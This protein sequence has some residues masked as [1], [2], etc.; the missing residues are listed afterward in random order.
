MR[1]KVFVA[2]RMSAIAGQEKLSGIFRYL[3]ERHS[4]EISLVR[5][6][7]EFTPER[8]RA[9]LGERFDGFIVSIPNTE[10][11]AVCLAHSSIP[12]IVMDI[13]DPAL[14]ARRSNILF[15][16]NSAEKIGTAA[17]LE[18]LG[19]GTCRSYAF[20]HNPLVA[21]WSSQRLRAFR[22]ALRDHGF[23]C[24][25]LAS[26]NGL[27]KI[28]RPVGVL[29]ANDDC[30]FDVLEYC[31]AH[32][33]KVPRDM[34]VLG[35]NNDTLICEHCRPA[36]SSIQPDYEQ[37]GFLAAQELDR[38]M[39]AKKRS[40]PPRTV[41]VGIRQIVRRASTAPYSPSGILV[42]KAVAYIDANA[43]HDIT[44]E[45]VVHHLKCSRRLADL[46]FRQL[47]GETMGER[48]T[49]IRLDEAKRLLRDTREPISNIA[50]R[51]GYTTSAHLMTLFRRKTGLTMGTY[52]KQFST[53]SDE[54]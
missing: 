1:K 9:A 11:S 43:L 32:H 40:V 45:A 27:E 13:H 5:A 29:A 28:E 54:R 14:E 2:L 30:G 36:L 51:C 16:R 37:E 21:E 8:V 20:V 25:E 22:E 23:W 31:H 46:R 38:M 7:S 35:I 6:A 49:R 41:F 48:I 26:P 47:Q 44:V 4:W 12:T 39:S 52:R 42:Q 17:A 24:H 50:A 10:P 53:G 33:I 3:G 34:L 18:L 15:I 19:T